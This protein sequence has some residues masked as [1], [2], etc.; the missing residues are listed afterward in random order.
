VVALSTIEAEYVAV[1]RAEQSAVYFRQLM[2]D[3]YQRQHG[4]TTFHEDN[5]GAVKLANNPM[6]SS[7]T[8]H[9]DIKHHYIRELVVAKTV[10]VVSM[11]TTCTLAYGATKAE[12]HDDLHA[13]HGSGAKWRLVCLHYCQ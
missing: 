2:Q 13:L 12:A 4:A 9:I 10:A 7:M 6:V 1:S 3:V 8:K 11:G 5:E